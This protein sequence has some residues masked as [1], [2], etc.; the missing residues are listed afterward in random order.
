[1]A[2]RTSRANSRELRIIKKQLLQ[3]FGTVCQICNCTLPLSKLVVEHKD[4]DFTNWGTENLQLACQS[5]NIKKNPPYS[6][7]KDIDFS[8]SHSLSTDMELRPQS[9]EMAR[10]IKS[11]PTFRKWFEKLMTQ[12]LRVELEEVINSGA[13]ISEVSTYTIRNNYLKKLCSDAG[14]YEIEIIDGIKFIKWKEK[15]FP[16]NEHMCKWSGK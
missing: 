1:M 7:K 9:I 15:F 5:C 14:L 8:Y 16:F 11:E 10:N 2:K 4:N 13:E 6:S 12:K 3:K